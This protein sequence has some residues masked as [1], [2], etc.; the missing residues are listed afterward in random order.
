LR[1]LCLLISLLCLS[2][3]AGVKQEI[4]LTA[5]VKIPESWR[6][7]VEGGETVSAKWW[8]RFGDEKLNAIVETALKNNIDI[9]IAVTRVE[10]AKAKYNLVR[11]Q[12]YP[13]L[14]L[15]LGAQERESLFQR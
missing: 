14:G 10:E 6:V 11:S 7:E 12:T 8:S 9:E 2:A 4:P 15:R 13:S 1:R 3:C 5:A